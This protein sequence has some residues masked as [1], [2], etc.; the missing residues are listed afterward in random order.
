MQAS[1]F[2]AFLQ[3]NQKRI[4]HYLISLTGNEPDAQDLVQ[5]VF[6]A[7]YEHIDRVEEA[8]ALAYLY[9][10]AH[11]KCMT[12]LKQKSRY[13]SADPKSFDHIPDRPQNSPEPDFSPLRDAVQALPPRLASVIQLQYYE[14]LSYKEISTQLGISVK[15]VES[16]LVRAKKILRKKLVK[17]IQGMGV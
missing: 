13:I 5:I 17:E 6:I 10:I 4:Y 1:Q 2:E 12:F 7:F 8:T 14:K 15:A 16:L 11:N 3:N 9:K